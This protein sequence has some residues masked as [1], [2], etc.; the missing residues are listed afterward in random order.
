MTVEVHK[1]GAD[2]KILEKG[3]SSM[4]T[5]VGAIGLSEGIK[6]SKAKIK[7][8]ED[9]INVNNST[10]PWAIWGD[11][12]DWPTK[13]TN[14]LDKLGVAKR[15][16]NLSADFHYGSGLQWMKE[17]VDLEA[18]T[19]KH[20]IS[21]PKGW[22]RWSNLSGFNRA[23]SEAIW[24]ADTFGI[25]WIRVTMSAGDTVY[26]CECLDTPSGRLEKRDP[27]SGRIKK[28][29]YAQEIELKSGKDEKTL[30]YPYY[31]GQEELTEFAKKNKVFVYPV[32]YSSWGKFYY[33]EPEYYAT[34]RNGWSDIAMAVPKLI[35]NIYA[36]QATLKYHIKIPI[37]Y[38]IM[39]YKDWD[40][41]EEKD[42][43]Q[44]IIEYRNEIE[45][46]ISNAEAAGKSIFS[47]Y[48]DTE[49][50][51]SLTIEP[52]KSALETTK[53]LPNNTAAN[54]EML[55]AIGIDPSLVGLN[56]PGAKD[57][58][59]G[60]GSQR[61]ESLKIKQATLTRERMVSLEFAWAVSILNKYDEEIYPMYVDID[62]SQTLDENPTGKRAVVSG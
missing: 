14:D 59:G 6:H 50:L 24:S 28:L 34:F 16:L 61:R 44:L 11:S 48:N 60:G 42:R 58:N 3:S 46:V 17:S 52:I 54:S 7:N 12:D 41:K 39:K 33:P 49:K 35:K 20:L 55:F 22:R 25:G 21:N 2:L 62:V 29:Y 37:S 5:V 13:V 57:L 43:L 26:N 51:E 4:V 18:G 10:K 40:A 19:L 38:F 23:L 27:S 31:D 36:N 30:E 47:L 1:I 9:S 53:D 32:A 45:T 15:A 8:L 56:M